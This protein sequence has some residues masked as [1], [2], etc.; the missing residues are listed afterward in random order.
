MDDRA[1]RLLKEG[2]INPYHYDIYMLYEGNDLGR[3]MLK[4][5]LLAAVMEE[6]VNGTG[7]AFAFAD[8]RRSVWREINLIVL[9]IHKEMEKS[10]DRSSNRGRNPA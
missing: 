7:E 2:K 10:H 5:H 8:G 1:T 9:N 3:R 4:E 6:P